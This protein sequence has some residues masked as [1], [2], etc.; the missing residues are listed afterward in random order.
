MNI[1]RVVGRVIATHKDP[2]YEGEKILI[3]QPISPDGSDRGKPVIALDSAGAGWKETV[4]Y[5]T[6]KEVAWP[7]LP[8][9]APSDCT[10]VGIVDAIN[11]RKSKP[12]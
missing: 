12:Q 4:L 7:F 9:P 11:I 1:G 3:V 2:S 5:V 8:D 10:I 6:A